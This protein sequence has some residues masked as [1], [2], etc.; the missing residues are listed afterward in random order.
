MVIN[1]MLDESKIMFLS[2][3]PPPQP[4]LAGEVDACSCATEREG[5]IPLV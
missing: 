4:I 1:T 2:M 3:H 5:N